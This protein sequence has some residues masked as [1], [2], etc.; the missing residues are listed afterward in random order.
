VYPWATG[1]LTVPK[2]K[3]NV[4][5]PVAV[6]DVVAVVALALCW[7]VLAVGLDVRDAIKKSSDSWLLEVDAD[8]VVELAVRW[9][10]DA[11]V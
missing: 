9:G 10:A 7:L 11:V 4:V 2:S 8:V 6:A 5:W 1:E 3:A